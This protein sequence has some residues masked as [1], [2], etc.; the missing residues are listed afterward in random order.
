M[1]FYKILINKKEFDKDL[2][3]VIV[4]LELDRAL[5]NKII[6]FIEMIERINKERD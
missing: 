6:K 3:D 2:Y 4:K 1:F 5:L